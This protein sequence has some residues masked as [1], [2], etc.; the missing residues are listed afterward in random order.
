MNDKNRGEIRTSGRRE[1]EVGVV[2]GVPKE[3]SCIC[4]EDVSR[5]LR[6]QSRYIP[7]LH[8]S[9]V[10]VFLLATIPLDLACDIPIKKYHLPTG[11]PICILLHPEALQY[12]NTPK[13]TPLN[14]AKGMPLTI[15]VEMVERSKRT[16]ATKKRTVKGV[17]GRS[18]VVS[19]WGDDRQGK[20]VDL[21]DNPIGALRRAYS[22]MRLGMV[23]G[24]W[25][26][27]DVVREHIGDD[28]DNCIEAQ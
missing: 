7:H 16:K 2:I 21:G 10:I 18:I 26:P 6:S 23:G 14:F 27:A 12:P 11:Y 3:G 5:R 4:R 22:L 1:R 20:R 17:A 28:Y 25:R 13:V 19:T 8:Q 24:R 9:V 15:G